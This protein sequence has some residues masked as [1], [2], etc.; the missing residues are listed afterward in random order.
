MYEFLDE[1]NTTARF[2]TA[3]SKKLLVAS[4]EPVLS[5]YYYCTCDSGQIRKERQDTVRQTRKQG[6]EDEKHF[7]RF[8]TKRCFASVFNGPPASKL[9]AKVVTPRLPILSVSSSSCGFILVFPAVATAARFSHYF[10]FSFILPRLLIPR[11]EKRPSR[12][13]TGKSSFLL[14]YSTHENS[15]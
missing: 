9:S 1:M 8:I 2:F 10:P 12:K 13:E 4:R 14:C 5:I 11:A 15:L 7:T 3:I 6:Q